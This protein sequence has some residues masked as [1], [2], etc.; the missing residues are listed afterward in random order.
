V[1]FESLAIALYLAKK[2]ANGKL[3][4]AAVR[5]ADA[6]ATRNTPVDRRSL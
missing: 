2:H 3:Y 6:P 4:P 1:L 5:K